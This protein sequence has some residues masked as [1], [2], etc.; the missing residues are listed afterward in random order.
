MLTASE[1]P[2][3]AVS[4]LCGFVI[5]TAA[6]PPPPEVITSVSGWAAVCAPAIAV[7]TTVICVPV[8]MVDGMLS[9]YGMSTDVT[10]VLNVVSKPPASP[11]AVTRAWTVSSPRLSVACV[12]N[13]TD[14]SVDEVCVSVTVGRPV[15]Q[16]AQVDP[17]PS[18][19]APMVATTARPK[20][21]A[22]RRRAGE[23]RAE[24]GFI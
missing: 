13:E 9:E 21:A 10:A 22:A 8:G 23:S 15:S 4:V 20:A 11:A 24:L 12:V 18:P 1:K 6:A 2:T 14:E 16:V 19:H 17:L 7:A 5:T 3:T